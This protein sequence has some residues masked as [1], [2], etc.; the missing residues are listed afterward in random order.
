MTT[1]QRIEQARDPSA[2]PLHSYDVFPAYQEASWELKDIP[3]DAFRPD[4]VRPEHIA[5]A[6][7]AVMG[8]SNSVAAQ[9]GFFNE[10]VDDYDFSAFVCLWGYQELQHHLAFKKWLRLA[11]EDVG[12]E[13]INA[14]RAPYP[15]GVTP[16]ATLATNVISEIATN[17]MYKCVSRVTPEP[18]LAKIMKRASGDEA[19][20][21]RE[22]IHYT[23]RRLGDR[24]E[25]LPS[26]LEV[27]YVYLADEKGKYQHPVSKFKGDLP[28]LVG[29]ITIDEVFRYFAEVDDGSEWDRIHRRLFDTL[30]E[31]SGRPIAKLRD[32]RRVLAD[33]TAPTDA[34]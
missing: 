4:L 21:A 22:F 34:G 24:P 26:V 31:L 23:A 1:P 12:Y 5:F 32:I 33:L 27:F 25:E 20:H 15:P 7:G 9:H 8:E 29:H 30:T 2:E 14:M 28:E 17:H 16:S 18:V 6:K 13:Q 3:W 11:G 10:F 19:R